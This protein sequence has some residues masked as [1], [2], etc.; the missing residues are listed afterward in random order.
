MC[1]QKKK[2]GETKKKKE[3]YKNED[4]FLF[5]VSFWPNDWYKL[6]STFFVTKES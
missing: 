3:K 5:Q 6:W 4:Q 2:E 1:Q